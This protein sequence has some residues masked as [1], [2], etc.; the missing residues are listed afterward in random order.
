MITH[1]SSH[2]HK[3][4][5]PLSRRRTA[6]LAAAEQRRQQCHRRDH[7]GRSHRGDIPETVP[8]R[9]VVPVEGVG[10][11]GWRRAAGSDGDRDSGCDFHV[12]A[13]GHLPRSVVAT[14]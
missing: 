6:H 5:I 8:G 9:S 13:V 3:S 7:A 11:V 4:Y 10:F 14:S 1:I 12:P 2:T